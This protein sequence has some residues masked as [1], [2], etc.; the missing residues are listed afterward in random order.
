MVAIKRT[1]VYIRLICHDLLTSHYPLLSSRIRPERRFIGTQTADSTK[2][3]WHG[4]QARDTNIDTL[5]CSEVQ[6]TSSARCSRNLAA[7][8]S[9]F[10]SKAHTNSSCRKSGKRFP[11]ADS[12]RCRRFAFEETF[13]GPECSDLHHAIGRRLNCTAW[14][15]AAHKKIDSFAIASPATVPASNLG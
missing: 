14:R 3:I 5:A 9:V 8:Y 12:A 2:R 6:F 13:G 7:L 15:H 11:M 10:Q 1:P 4:C